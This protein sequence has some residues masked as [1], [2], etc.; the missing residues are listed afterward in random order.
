[1]TGFKVGDPLVSN[2]SSGKDGKDLWG[3]SF[4]AFFF[5]IWC[6]E[7]VGLV[8]QVQGVSVDLSGKSFKAFNKN[9][10]LFCLVKNILV[11]KLET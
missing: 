2:I 11:E 10:L 5:F 1:M 4:Q 8:H 9:K 3:N 7:L 6:K